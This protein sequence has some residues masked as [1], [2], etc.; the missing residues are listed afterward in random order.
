MDWN[1]IMNTA[2]ATLCASIISI[3]GMLLI[4]WLGNRK[5]YKDIDGKMGKLDNK[6]LVG[7]IEEKIGYL[8]NTSLSGQHAHIEEV[9]SNKIGDLGDITLSGQN[10]T[11]L[12]EIQGFKEDFLKSQKYELL[13]RQQL[14]GDQAKIDQS[15][16]ALSAFSKLMVDVQTETIELKHKNKLL[17]EENIHLKQ[18]NS[19]FLT[20]INEEQKQEEESQK[21]PDMKIQ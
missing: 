1:F 21:E 16:A 13:K 18:E 15:I 8:E 7:L 3:S 2:I 9:I 5:G 10:K 17:E 14:T 19:E 20:Q 4:N 6:T 12:R 11:L